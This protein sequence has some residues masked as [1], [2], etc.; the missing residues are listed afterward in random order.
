MTFSHVGLPMVIACVVSAWGVKMRVKDRGYEYGLTRL[1]PVMYF[2]IFYSLFV[3]NEGEWK[4]AFPCL[5]ILSFIG[6]IGAVLYFGGRPITKLTAAKIIR[7]CGHCSASVQPRGIYCRQCGKR[8]E[9]F[10]QKVIHGES[11]L[12]L[13]AFVILG[14]KYVKLPETKAPSLL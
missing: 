14:G 5:L 3:F 2:P 9:G 12:H 4:W 7:A 13:I 1:L 8:L 6:H 10:P 11:I